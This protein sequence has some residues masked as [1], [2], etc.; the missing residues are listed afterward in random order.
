MLGLITAVMLVTTFSAHA[1]FVKDSYIITFKKPSGTEKP[2]IDPPNEMNRGKTPVGMHST[3]QSK[4][5]LAAQLNLKGKVISIL[6]TI[7]AVH[8]NMT[9]DEAQRLSLDPRVLYVQQDM[10]ATAAIQ[11][12]PGWA[13]DRLD[14]VTPLLDNTYND[15]PSNGTGRTIYILDSGIALGNATVAAEFG[16][17]AS[18]IWDVNTGG[19]GNDC[20]GHGTQVASAAAGN[21][22]GT[23]KG[24]TVIAAKITTDC[25]GNTSTSTSTTLFNWL[26]ANAPRGSIANWSYEF[27]D[28][29]CS[30]PTFDTTLENAIRAAH[31]AGVIVVVAA[32][33]NPCNTANYTPTRIQE[34]FVV[35]ATSRN[36]I[37][38]NGQDEI[39]SFSRFGWNI[40][41]FAPGESVATLNY[42]GVQTLVNGTSFSAPYVAGLFATACQASGTVCNTATSAAP[43]YQLMRDSGT[44]NTVTNVGGSTLT[45]ST[46]RFLYKSW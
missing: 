6:E 40:S 27:R 20:F 22:Y 30:N 42:T 44:L 10:I 2:I 29:T 28:T 18:V 13:L 41:T 8:V 39:T 17:R 26:A 4:E 35:G 12:N 31:N 32:G 24:A 36:R 16:G 11:N 3:G 34:A 25:T 14:E 43:L 1:E 23:A 33:N 19:T 45:G 21:T 9:A 5:K 46:S 38:S 15:S 37:A 7:N